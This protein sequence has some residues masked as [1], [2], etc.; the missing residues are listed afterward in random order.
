MVDVCM[1]NQRDC[2]DKDKCYRYNAKPSFMQSWFAEDPRDEDK[3]F[4][5]SYWPMDNRSAKE[6]SDATGDEF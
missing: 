6:I 5:P 1:C 2:R 4:C 3:N